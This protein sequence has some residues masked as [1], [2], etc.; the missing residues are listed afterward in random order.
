MSNVTLSFYLGYEIKD[1]DEV[2]K[3]EEC[4]G[5]IKGLNF[6]NAYY[7]VCRDMMDII[8]DFLSF[9]QERKGR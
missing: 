9:H 3:K 4:Y 6:S 1:G 5:P 2:L 8:N 7:R